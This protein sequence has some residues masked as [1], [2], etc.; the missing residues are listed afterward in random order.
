M[1]GNI[2]RIVLTKIPEELKKDTI[3]QYMGNYVLAPE[4]NFLKIETDD[5]RL[6]HIENGDVEILHQGLKRPL[7]WRIFVGPNITGILKST[8]QRPWEGFKTKC[9]N[10][11]KLGH[12]AYMCEGE[13]ACYRCKKPGHK[14]A[15]CKQCGYCSRWGHTAE[16]C[17]LNPDNNVTRPERSQRR[18]YGERRREE[19][20]EVKED[21]TEKN[22]R[23]EENKNKN[24]KETEGEKENPIE[25]RDK[26]EEEANTGKERKEDFEEQKD[27]KESDEDE[28]R[29]VDMEINKDKTEENEIDWWD[30]TE[31]GKNT[32]LVDMGDVTPS[33]VIDYDSDT[34]KE[35]TK[36][37]QHARETTEKTS[38]IKKK[39]QETDTKTGKISR[40]DE[41]TSED[42]DED[43]D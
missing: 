7:P 13:S 30:E 26:E 15:E 37:L 4:V 40:V 34:E 10:C 22:N 17:W 16:E 42:E 9:T 8:T 11:Q 25:I 43:E 29:E 18:N 14:G 38:A 12:L 32:E 24:T 5:P 21:K 23:E 36:Q 2:H 41:N 39:N 1:Y 3:E 19:K 33:L 6:K 28:S 20:G 27:N 31:A 35:I